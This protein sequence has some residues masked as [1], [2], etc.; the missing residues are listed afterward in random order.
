MMQQPPI[1]E[2]SPGP[3]TLMGMEAAPS[4]QKATD[5]PPAS[6]PAPL[7]SPPAQTA[8]ESFD[9]HKTTIVLVMQYRPV[10]AEGQS[11]QV[12]ISAQNGLGNTDDFPIYHACT[13]EELGPM[14]PVVLEVLEALQQDLPLRKQRRALREIQKSRGVSTPSRPGQ[15]QGGQAPPAV[16]P[17]A[18]L[19]PPPP[20]PTT[21]SP[22]PRQDLELTSLFEGQE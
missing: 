3:E 2:E 18:K 21:S 6:A 16:K 19:A 4:G 10:T 9:Y 11:R 15:K 20:P 1:T 7:A 22:V 13:E 17:A 8:V 5:M 12:W 14:P